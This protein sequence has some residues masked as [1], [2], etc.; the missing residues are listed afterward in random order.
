[1]VEGEGSS[2]GAEVNGA[3]EGAAEGEVGSIYFR[4]QISRFLLS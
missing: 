3:G 4:F 2:G 1:M